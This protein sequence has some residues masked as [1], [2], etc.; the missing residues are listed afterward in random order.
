MNA[1]PK[2][3]NSGFDLSYYLD[4]FDDA[5]SKRYKGKTF[6]AGFAAI[7]DTYKDISAGKRRLSVG[8]VMAIFADELPFVQDWTRPDAQRLEQ[9]MEEHGVPEAIYRLRNQNNESKVLELISQIRFELG[10]LG[11]TSLVLHHVYPARFAM[12][13]HH[14]ASLLYVVNASTV[15]KFYLDYCAE[16]NLWGTKKSTREL[17]VVQTEFALWTWYRMAHHSREEEKKIHKK[18]FFGDPWIQERRAKK[19]AEALQGLGRLDVARSYLGVDNN[20]AGI[21]AWV[22]FELA[23]RSLLGAKKRKTGMLDLIRALPLGAVPEAR[24]V[25]E[26]TWERNGRGRNQVMHEGLKLEL[27]EAKEIVGQV[28][29]FLVY[30]S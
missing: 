14:L 11:L 12:C 2:K 20:L 10:D 30:N 5:L 18:K 15:P 25:L 1:N 8:D 16:L 29:K 27:L 22:E 4:H 6:R 23:V 13:S 28:N 3:V 7:K 26:F 17:D 9:R 19:I 21:I 24:E